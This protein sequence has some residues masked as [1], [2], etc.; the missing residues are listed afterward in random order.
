MNLQQAINVLKQAIDAGI[1]LGV[2]QNIDS[3]GILA[4]AW[5]IITNNLKH[6]E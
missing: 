1:K 6:E 5:Q 2:C 4:Q 3:A